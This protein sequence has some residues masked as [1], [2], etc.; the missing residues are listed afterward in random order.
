MEYEYFMVK[1]NDNCLDFLVGKKIIK[2]LFN[3]EKDSFS[4]ILDS[5]RLERF[6]CEGE[7]CSNSWIEHV[8]GLKSLLGHTINK[9]VF[10]DLP[11]DKEYGEE[12]TLIYR[13]DIHTN[14]GIC[15]M[16]MRNH[17]NGYYCGELTRIDFED[18]DSKFDSFSDFQNPTI[19]CTEDF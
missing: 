4:F 5:L 18:D 9:I 19:E 1:T 2:L 14:E 13:W 10:I 12:R 8:S 15:T 17:S 16:E 7:C 3:E 11:A 6:I